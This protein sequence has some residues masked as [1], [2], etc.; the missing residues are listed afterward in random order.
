MLSIIVEEIIKDK[1]LRGGIIQPVGGLGYDTKMLR[2]PAP[3]PIKA[4]EQA[5]KTQL[6]LQKKDALLTARSKKNVKKDE[7]IAAEEVQGEQPQ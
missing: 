7:A 5:Q 4:E 6:A 1:F 2:Q 3:G